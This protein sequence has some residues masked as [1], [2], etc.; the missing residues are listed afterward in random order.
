M[1]KRSGAIIICIG[2]SVLI[3]SGCYTQLMTPQEFIQT[4]RHQSVRTIADN[5]YALN[6]NQSCVTCHSVTELNERSEELEAYGTLSVHN[7]YALSSRDWITK[8]Q[9]NVPVYLPSPS[10]DPNPYWPPTTSTGTSWW[11]PAPSNSFGNGTNDRPRTGGATRD[12]PVV[13]DRPQSSTP[14]VY[15]NPSP[16]SGTGTAPA[17]VSTPTVST[18][19]PST[20]APSSDSGRSRD[21]STTVDP[22]GRTR[23]DGSSRDENNSRPR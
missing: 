17:P 13:R 20:P 1:N 9:G 12:T 19:P 7:G 23:S 22:S 11:S 5:S 14:P 10:P 21:N 16:S 6:Y 18:P 4:Q 15:T 8:T 3:L 2:C